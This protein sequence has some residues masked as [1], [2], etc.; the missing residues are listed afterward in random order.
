MFWAGAAAER[1]SPVEASAAAARPVAYLIS[2]D[3]AGNA[4]YGGTQSDAL[5][6][7][8]IRELKARGY[9]VTLA[10]FLVMDAP[11]FPWRGRIG[12][13]QDGT[14]SA[15]TE[16]EAYLNGAQGYRRFILRHAALA[17]EAGGV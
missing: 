15:R 1:I 8:A 4:I 13:S 12:V 3:E 7:Q 17:A 9:A 10:P 6:A 11:G 14:A 2:Q 16:I 5:V